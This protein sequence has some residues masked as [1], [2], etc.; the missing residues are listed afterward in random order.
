MTKS[1]TSGAK[2]PGVLQV[3]GK[4]TLAGNL[5]LTFASGATLPRYTDTLTIFSAS[6]PI[7]G[8]FA[9]V[10]NGARIDT[11]DGKGSFQVS[12]G[13][14]SGSAPTQIVLSH[15]STTLASVITSPKT[16]AGT[17]GKAFSYQ[18][19]ASNGPTKFGASGLPGGLTIDTTTG[20][21]TGTPTAAGKSTVTLYAYNSVGHSSA[22]LTLTVAAA[23]PVITSAA[24]A[25]ATVG[26][27]FSYQITA[28]NSPTRYGV[29]GLLAGF[30]VN[31]QTGLLTGTPTAAQA[32]TH[33]LTLQ[34]A[35]AGGTG[36]K[37]LALTVSN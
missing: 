36:T 33:S 26:K 7:T 23:Q 9:N 5:I 11:A 34:A 35:N 29:G 28:T 15:F 22:I 32:G 13:A 12:Y 17:Q 16:A 10:A 14:T 2:S 8:S 37:T 4:A 3:N 27:A 30:T 18:I 19:T 1:A 20:A 25:T 31:A 6:V 21:I 24:T